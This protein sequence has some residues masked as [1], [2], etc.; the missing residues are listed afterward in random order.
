MDVLIVDHESTDGTAGL[1]RARGA[2]VCVRPFEGFVKAREFA[3][4]Q[5]RTPWTLMIDADEALDAALAA[6]IVNA[7]ADCEG[8]HVSRTTFYCGKALRMWSGEMLLR[9]FRTDRA[10]LQAFPAAGG[11]AQVHERW[12][13]AGSTGTLPGTLLHYSYPSDDAYR[14]KFERYTAIEAGGLEPS[15]ARAS[16]EALRAP[17]RF[18]WYAVRRG[19]ALDGAAGLRIA[20]RSA[21]YPAVVQWKALRR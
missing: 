21:L 8:Y 11:A 9:L 7:P 6:A 12:T 20:W 2:R 15:L 16:I 14:S 1:A 13:C 3:L 10:R 17:L 4:A 5:V 18:L 19:A